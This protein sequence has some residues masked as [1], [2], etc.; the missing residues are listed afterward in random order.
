MIR[1]AASICLVP[2]LSGGPVLYS[3]DLAESCRRAAQS[4]FDA[5]E[6]LAPSGKELQPAIIR[7]LL[8]SHDLVLSGVGTGAGF[9]KHGLPL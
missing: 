6:L 3:G 2:E 1:L 4:G 9:L 5:V 8:K 7:P